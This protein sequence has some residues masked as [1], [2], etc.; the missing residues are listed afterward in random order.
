MSRKMSADKWLY[1][2]FILPLILTAGTLAVFALQGVPP[3]W[4]FLGRVA[5]EFGKACVLLLRS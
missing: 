4:V 1:I 3:P 5:K 2:I